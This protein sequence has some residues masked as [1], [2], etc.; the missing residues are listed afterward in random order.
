MI[1]HHSHMFIVIQRADEDII[2][3]LPPKTEKATPE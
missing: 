1:P 2:Q 3:F